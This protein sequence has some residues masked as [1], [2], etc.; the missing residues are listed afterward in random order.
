MLMDTMEHYTNFKEAFK[1]KPK[2]THKHFLS[3]FHWHTTDLLAP[4]F[5]P[6]K[7]D[8]YKSMNNV[9]QYPRTCIYIH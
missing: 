4:I 7:C 9:H 1:P 3:P 5:T 8:K 6:P 2:N